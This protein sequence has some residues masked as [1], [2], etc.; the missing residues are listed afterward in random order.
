MCPGRWASKELHD[1]AG[2]VAWAMT[3]TIR[4]RRPFVGKTADLL[5][6]PS[7]IANDKKARHEWIQEQLESRRH[8]KQQEEDE[9][10]QEVARQHQR[11]W[12]PYVRQA[13]RTQELNIAWKEELGFFSWDKVLSVEDLLALRITGHSLVT[14][15]DTISQRLSSLTTLSLIS[16]KLQALPE[17]IGDIKSLTEIDLTRNELR[18]LPESL[19]TLP[20]LT[21]LNLSA[22]QLQELPANFGNLDKLEKIWVEKNQLTK[23]PASIGQCKARVANFNNNLL[24][25]LPDTICEMTNLTML[26]LNMNQLT[27]L[28]ESIVRTPLLTTIHASKNLLVRLPRNIGTL[29][30]LR[31]LWLDWNK[32]TELP[33]SFRFLT[34]LQV[35]RMERNPLK[36]PPLEY[37][38]RGIPATIKYIEKSVEDFVRK[39]RRQ[40]VERLEEILEFAAALVQSGQRDDDMD[41]IL[42]HFEPNCERMVKGKETLQFHAVVW[43]AFYETLLPALE[44]KKAAAD[45]E[46]PSFKF[47]EFSKEE[48]EDALECYDDV[49]GAASM[50]DTADFRKCTCIDMFEWRRHGVRKR[51]VC[52]PGQVPYKCNREALMIRKQMM[53]QEEAKDQLA[54]TYLK[55]KIDRLVAKTKRKCIIYVNSEEGVEHFEKLAATLAKALFQKRKRLKKIR[56]KHD[57]VSKKFDKQRKQLELKIEALMKAK[58]SRI[59]GLEDQLAQLIKD[60]AKFEADGSGKRAARLEK[61]GGKIVKIQD[62][63]AAEPVEDKKILGIELSLEALDDAVMKANAMT[64]KAREK[65]LEA[66]D[67]DEDEDEDDDD[68]DADDEGGD[69]DNGSDGDD[70]SNEND[71]DSDDEV[72]KPPSADAGTSTFFKFDMPNMD[73]PDYRKAATKAIEAIVDEE[74][75]T[76]EEEFVVLFQTQVRDSYMAERLTLVERKA[77][78]E[79]LQM[80]AV[81]RRWMGLGN[82]AVFEA[83]REVVIQ[84]RVD[85]VKTKEKLEKKKLIEEQ[86]R[87]LQEQLMRLEA[88]KWVQ[89]VDMYTDDIYYANNETGETSWTPPM[90]WEEEQAAMTGNQTTSAVPTLKLPPI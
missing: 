89:K 14:L 50:K 74:K 22:N 71:D 5:N 77:T 25:E 64:E 2:V 33:F 4:S 66:G 75:E 39:A 84:N 15:P 47:D 44:R 31:E 45:P 21:S 41:D 29:Q 57:K 43:D 42:P 52:L 62:E 87:V 46:A 27:E 59:K 58:E 11:L 72:P 18:Q 65:E 86:N 3:V 83:W 12:S 30:T 82:R 67:E 69:D 56:L 37:V 32:I 78:Y 26:S 1:A 54:S 49:F 70:Q 63:L 16:N 8:Q 17:N 60:K 20:Q 24:V 85:A 61:I 13:A 81:L 9:Q 40:I 53:T 23:L 90:Y 35:L 80:R 76:N 28:P 19:T 48:V 10:R 79:F 6:G 51:K 38:I 88:R 68:D 73:V 55:R 7:E 34:Q 36:Q